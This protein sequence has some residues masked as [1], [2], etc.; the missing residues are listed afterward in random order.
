VRGLIAEKLK[1][2]NI[3]ASARMETSFSATFCSFSIKQQVHYLRLS[4]VFEQMWNSPT[5][6]LCKN[7]LA[8]AT[9]TNWLRFMV[10]EEVVNCNFLVIIKVFKYAWLT[11]LKLCWITLKHIFPQLPHRWTKCPTFGFLWICCYNFGILIFKI[12]MVLFARYLKYPY[13]EP[14]S[15]YT[16]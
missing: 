6:K 4:F 7:G 15:T 16:L 2:W 9:S 14:Q 3:Y 13:Q 10:R 5:F 11:D 1:C 8:A 12:C